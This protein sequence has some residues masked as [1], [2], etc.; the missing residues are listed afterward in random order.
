MLKFAVAYI[1]ESHLKLKLVEANDW[2]HALRVVGISIDY[3]TTS[4]EM[5]NNCKEIKLTNHSGNHTAIQE[6][7]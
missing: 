4:I 1:Y 2:E 5:K 7:F 6:I 3:T